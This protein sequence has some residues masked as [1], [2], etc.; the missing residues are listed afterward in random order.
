MKSFW[1]KFKRNQRGMAAVIIGLV[2]TF[3]TVGV[4][5][6]VGLMITGEM[7]TTTDAMDLGATGNT[8]RDNLFANIYTGFDLSN[9]LPIIIAASV[10][11]S[12]VVGIMYVRSR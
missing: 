5:L 1:S 8:T 9:I 7:D 11:I 4:V 12:A 2:V 6:P 3:V 10:I